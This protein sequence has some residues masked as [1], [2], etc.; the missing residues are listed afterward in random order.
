MPISAGAQADLGD[1]AALTCQGCGTRR[2]WRHSLPPETRRPSDGGPTTQL[3]TETKAPMSHPQGRASKGQG[4]N[5]QGPLCLARLFWPQ[6]PALSSGMRGWR[7][8]MLGETMEVAG[9]TG[10]PT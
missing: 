4:W 3:P 6:R 8:W 10:M 5:C 2:P 7:L 9:S 1:H